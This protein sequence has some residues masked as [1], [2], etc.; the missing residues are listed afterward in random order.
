MKTSTCLKRKSASPVLNVLKKN[1]T[2]TSYSDIRDGL[3]QR[4]VEQS[5]LCPSL[6]SRVGFSKPS[7]SGEET[8]PAWRTAILQP[9]Q[10]RERL[11]D[12]VHQLTLREVSNVVPFDGHFY[13]AIT[14]GAD[15][16]LA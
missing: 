11:R 3:L 7:A 14:R 12:L 10:P 4:C 13:L 6:P 16:S 15:K 8:R 9:L 2:E 1:T 5:A